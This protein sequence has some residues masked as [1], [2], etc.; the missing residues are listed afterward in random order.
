MKIKLVGALPRE[1][2]DLDLKPGQTFDAFPAEKTSTRAV[3]FYIWRDGKYTCTVWPE[4][5]IEVK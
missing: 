3:Q 4:N 2:K 5:F 1:L